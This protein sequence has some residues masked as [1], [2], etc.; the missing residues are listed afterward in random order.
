MSYPSSHGV[1][2][3]QS[4]KAP[5]RPPNA[6]MLYRSAKLI[7]LRD[8]IPPEEHKRQAKL[9]KSIAKMWHSESE[10][11]KNYYVEFAERKKAEHQIAYPD[12]KYRPMRK[13]DKARLKA[14]KVVQEDIVNTVSADDTG[15]PQIWEDFGNEE[16]EVPQVSGQ[17]QY[18]ACMLCFTAQRPGACLGP[19]AVPPP[20][21]VS[22]PPDIPGVRYL[23]VPVPTDAYHQ[24]VHSQHPPCQTIDPF[25]LSSPYPLVY[26]SLFELQEA[27]TFLTNPPELDLTGGIDLA[28]L[29]MSSWL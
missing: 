15:E 17:C 26:S 11:V 5:P 13:A 22:F 3:S 1:V 14:R 18:Q 2:S 29:N 7:E 23:F 27:I 20:P 6:F 25:A 19:M 10:V 8:Q 12:Y 21:P 28:K 9:S 24:L 4:S 16:A